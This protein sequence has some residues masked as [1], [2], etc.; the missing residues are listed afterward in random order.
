MD[1]AGRTMN[2]WSRTIGRI[3]GMV[4][5][6]TIRRLALGLLFL[7]VALSLGIYNYRWPGW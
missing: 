6:R 7:L 3:M 4:A 1:E 5:Q 2:R